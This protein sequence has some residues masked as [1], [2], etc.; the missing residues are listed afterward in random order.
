MGLLG[1]DRHFRRAVLA[2]VCLAQILLL[3]EAATAANCPNGT[4]VCNAPGGGSF[5]C[6]LY[7]SGACANND[8]ICTAVCTSSGCCNPVKVN[9]ALQG[10]VLCN[11]QCCAGVCNTTTS[12]PTCVPFLPASCPSGTD[13]CNVPGGGSLCCPLYQSGMCSG[14]DNICSTDCTAKGCCAPNQVSAGGA[15]VACGQPAQ[16][17]CLGSSCVGTACLSGICQCP[18]AGQVASHGACVPC[19]ASGEL[20]CAHG[21]NAGNSCVAGTCQ[22]CGATG[23]RCCGGASACDP[24]NSCVA[25]TCQCGGDGQACCRPGYTCA[26]GTVC[27]PD[28]NCHACGGFRQVCC[29][30]NTCNGLTCVPSHPALCMCGDLGQACCS[31]GCNPGF[32]CQNNVCSSPNTPPPQ[33]VGPGGACGTST[34]PYCCTGEACSFGFCKT[35]FNHGD[36]CFPGVNEICCSWKDICRLDQFSGKA[37]CDIRD[38]PP[39]H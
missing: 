19:G 38:A 4:D 39:G 1:S 12:P 6:E 3:S 30:N 7:Q 5:C 25:G 35:C 37:T 13:V 22:P 29:E 18:A 9:G 2:Q 11:G 14:N 28:L 21:C 36:Q 31:G 34:G 23:Q 10:Q 24:G 27:E 16:P 15:C 32:T 20:C 33:C 26:S 17:C 8:N